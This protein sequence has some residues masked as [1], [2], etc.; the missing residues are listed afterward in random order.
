MTLACMMAFT[1]MPATSFASDITDGEMAISENDASES[2]TLEPAYESDVLPDP[3]P[4]NVTPALNDGMDEN[5]GDIIPD[6]D[7]VSPDADPGQETTGMDLSSD[8]LIEE[9]AKPGKILSYTSD[10][11]FSD[12]PDHTLFSLEVE[13]NSVFEQGQSLLVKEHYGKDLAQDTEELRSLLDDTTVEAKLSFTVLLKNADGTDAPV[14]EELTVRVYAEEKD[15]NKDCNL[16]FYGADKEWKELSFKVFDRT[17]ETN[18]YVEFKTNELGKV[19]FFENTEQIPPS[20]DTDLSDPNEKPLTPENG[21]I[22]SDLTDNVTTQEP[23][24][25]TTAET[26]AEEETTA[27]TQ[28]EEETT[29]ETQAEE[30][31]TAETQAEEAADEIETEGEYLS[32]EI[33][34][35]GDDLIVRVTITEEN[36]IP[37]GAELCV[38]KIDET[39][40]VYQKYFEDLLAFYGVPEE[41]LTIFPYDVHFEFNGNEIEPATGD[42]AVSFEMKESVD[43]AD[44]ETAS[45]LHICDNGEIEEVVENAGNDGEITDFDFTVEAFSGIVIAKLGSGTNLLGAENMTTITF[46][47]TGGVLPI[48]TRQAELNVTTAEDLP[49][50]TKDGHVFLGWFSQR[51]GGYQLEEGDV[52]DRTLY[53]AQWE[54]ITY[55]LILHPNGTDAEPLE[56]TLRYRDVLDLNETMFELDGYILGSWNTNRFGTGESYPANTDV[57]RL[58]ET[59]GDT[60]TLYAIWSDTPYSITFDEQGGSEVPDIQVADGQTAGNK[61]INSQKEGYT[62]LGWYTRPERGIQIKNDTVIHSDYYL[63]ARFEKN[64]VVTFDP[65]D[66]NAVI[67]E[68]DRQRELSYGGTIGELPRVING[69]KDFIGWFTR[70]YG[71]TQISSGAIVYADTTYYAHYGYKPYFDTAEGKIITPDRNQAKQSPS[72]TV[73]SFPVVRR[74]GYDFVGWFLPDGET[75]VQLGDV[76]DLSEDKRIIAHWEPSNKAVITL[77]YDNGT[78]SPKPTSIT[79]YK[80]TALEQL[81][82]PTRTGYKFAGWYDEEG[83]LYKKGTVIT[84]NTALKA[85]WVEKNVTVTF[86]PQG[87][88]NLYYSTMTLPAGDTLNF[89]PGASKDGHILLGWYTQPDGQGEKLTTDTEIDENTTYYAYWVP[90]NEYIDESGL[91]YTYTA[92]WNNNSNSQVNNSDNRLVFTPTS[93]GAVTARLYVNFELEKTVEDLYLPAGALEVR[94]PK[95]VWKSWNGSNI[96]STNI[97]ELFLKAPEIP[98]NDFFNYYEEPDYYV[99]T[100]CVPLNGGAG[101]LKEF[102]YR[103][104]PSSVRG[105]ATDINGDF[106]DG[107]RYFENTVNVSVKIDKELDGVYDTTQRKQLSLEMHTNLK[108]SSSKMA[109]QTRYQ[110]D[111]SWGTKPADAE[112]Y[113]Y[114]IWYVKNWASSSS[115]QGGTYTI[116]EA[117]TTHDGT[118]VYDNFPTSATYT[119]N[120]NE[121]TYT[122]V[123]K[124]SRELL[125][126]AVL[127]PVTLH[128]EAII[129]DTWQSG[130]TTERRVNATTRVSV[131]EHPVGEFD[132][133][134]SRNS[135]IITGGQEQIVKNGQE[136]YIPFYTIYDGGSNV[137]PSWD[138]ATKTYTTATRRMMIQ[139]GRPGDLKYSSGASDPRYAWNANV[140]DCVLYDPD[141]ALKNINITVTEYDSE[142][143]SDKWLTPWAHTDRSTFKP[144]NVYV[145]YRGE[146]DFTFYRTVPL[147]TSSSATVNFPDNVVGYRVEHDSNFFKTQIIVSGAWYLEPTGRVYQLIADDVDHDTTSIIKNQ[148][149]C[150]LWWPQREGV[151]E[152]AGLGEEH[153][154]FDVTAWRYYELNISK[155]TLNCD[156]YIAPA[157]VNAANGTQTSRV[158]I[159]GWNY[160]NSGTVYKTD[161]GVLYDLLPRGVSV[162]KDTVTGYAITSARQWYGSNYSSYGTGQR[163]DKNY[164]NVTFVDNWEGSGRTMMI[165][166]FVVPK[167]IYACGVDFYYDMT[168]SMSNIE[169]YGTARENDLAYAN[170]SEITREIS[171]IR[172]SRDIITEREY[173]DSIAD[174]HTWVAYSRDYT[175]FKTVISE[176]WGFDKSVKTETTVNYVFDGATPLNEDYT[177]KLRMSQSENSEISNLVIYD[178][179]EA[180]TD[181]ITSEWLGSFVSADA[182][183]FT[184]IKNKGE[185]V[186]ATCAPVLY[187]STKPRDEFPDF[188]QNISVEGTAYDLTNTTIWSTQLPDNLGDVTAVAFDMRTDTDGNPMI[189]AGKQSLSVYIRMHSPSNTDLVELTNGNS[190]VMTSYRESSGDTTYEH[191]EA[192]VRIIDSIPELHKT[193]VPES[194]TMEEPAIVS[195]QEPL[196]YTLS[197]ENTG[198]DFILKDVVVEDEIPEGL[199]LKSI[200]VHFG[201]PATKINIEDSPRVSMETDGRHKTFTIS[202]LNKKETCYIVI[203]TLAT[204][205]ERLFVNSS[206]ITSVN[207]IDR[208]I[209]SETTYHTEENSLEVEIRKEK[210]S[211]GLLSGASLQILDSE[212]NIVES[213]VSTSQPH[214][215]RLFPG[216]YTLH[217]ESA[218][219]HFQTAEDITFEVTQD[220]Y[221]KVNGTIA[222]SVKMT[223]VETTDVEGEKYWFGDK[224]SA[225]RPSS[226][227]VNLLRDGEI[228]DTKEVTAADE[229]KYSWTELPKYKEPG[230]EYIYKVV[231]AEVPEGYTFFEGTGEVDHTSTGID[232]VFSSS[233]ETES[234]SYDWIYFYYQKDGIWYR[235]NA[236]GGTSIKNTHVRIP[237]EMAYIEFRSDGS[238]TKYG[239]SF[240]SITSYTGTNFASAT[241]VSGLPS[242]YTNYGTYIGSSYPSYVYY[243]NNQRRRWLYKL[244]NN[245]SWEGHAVIKPVAEGEIPY[246]MTNAKPTPVRIAKIGESNEYLPGAELL[247]TGTEYLSGREVNMSITSAATYSTIDLFPGEYTLHEVLPPPG[248]Y[249][250]QDV[251]FRVSLEGEITFTGTKISNTDVCIKD[252]R[253]KLYVYKYNRS[254]NYLAG[255]TFQIWREADVLDP[256]SLSFAPEAEPVAEWTTQ[257][258][259]QYYQQLLNSGENYWL[260]E[261]EV[262]EGFEK[263]SPYF[264]QVAETATSSTSISVSLYNEW[265]PVDIS[266]S[267]KDEDGNFVEGATLRLTGTAMTN[268]NPTVNATTSVTEEWVTTTEAKHLSLKPGNYVLTEIKRPDSNEYLLN[269]KSISIYVSNDRQVYFYRTDADGVSRRTDSAD[270]VM[271]DEFNKTSLP[272]K[273]V[274]NDA[275]YEENRP[276]SVT[277]ELYQNGTKYE[278]K[279]L[280]SEDASDGYTWEGEFTDLPILDPDDNEYEYEIN[281][282]AD[283]E[284]YRTTYNSSETSGMLITFSEDSDLGDG[285]M[286]LLV[287]KGNS[288]YRSIMLDASD[289]DSE[290]TTTISGDRIGG[291]TI[292]VPTR[293]TDGRIA[294]LL[295]EATKSRNFTITQAMPTSAVY[296]GRDGVRDSSFNET[297]ITSVWNASGYPTLSETGANQEECILFTASGSSE[298]FV[299]A[300]IITNT[301]L[302]T[303]VELKKMWEDGGD[304]ENRPDTITLDLYNEKDLE[305]PVDTIVLTT[306]DSDGRDTWK[307]TI[308][309]LP[310]Y[311]PDGTEA[312]YLYRERSVEGYRTFYSKTDI[313]GARI[314]LSA[315]STTDGGTLNFIVPNSTRAANNYL[316]VN[317][318]RDFTSV[319]GLEVFVPFYTDCHDVF[320]SLTGAGEN[321][322]ITIEN[323]TPISAQDNELGVVYGT[324]GD[325]SETGYFS[326]ENVNVLTENGVIRYRY[327]GESAVSSVGS[328][329]V[330]ESTKTSIMARKTWQDEGKEA[331]RPASVTVE[332][333]NENDPDTVIREAELTGDGNIWELEIQDL[334]RYNQDGTPAHYIVREK[335]APQNYMTFYENAASTGYLVTFAQDQSFE[336]TVTFY[337]LETAGKTASIVSFNGK[338]NLTASDIAGAQIYIEKRAFDGFGFEMSNRSASNALRVESIK[339]VT[340]SSA[341]GVNSYSSPFTRLINPVAVTDITGQSFSTDE[342]GAVQFGIYEYYS[343]VTQAYYGSEIVNRYN[344]TE[345]TAVKK[346]EG[347]SEENRPDTITFNLYTETDPETVIDSKTITKTETQAVFEDLPKYNDDGSIIRYIVKEEEAEGYNTYYAKEE[348]ETAVGFLVEFEKQ[349]YLNSIFIQNGEKAGSIPR[350]KLE[351]VGEKD[352]ASSYSGNMDQNGR[353]LFIPF[354]KDEN[355]NPVRAFMVYGSGLKIKTIEPAY[356]ENLLANAY[357]AEYT[358]TSTVS[359]YN[360]AIFTG[361]DFPDYASVISETGDLN[362][363]SSQNLYMTYIGPG[364]E[365]PVTGNA[366]ITNRRNVKD[367]PFRKIF[368]DAGFESSRPE[369]I[370]VYL[371]DASGNTVSEKEVAVTGSEVTGVFEDIPYLDDAGQEILYHVEEEVPAGYRAFYTMSD[372]KGFLVTFSDDT[373]LKSNSMYLLANPSSSVGDSYYNGS[374]SITDDTYIP[375]SSITRTGTSLAGKTVYIPITKNYLTDGEDPYFALYH[376]LYT[377]PSKTGRSH[378]AI[379]N[380]CLTN[381]YAPHMFTADSTMTYP[382]RYFMKYTGSNY[383]GSEKSMGNYS[384]GSAADMSMYTWSPSVNPFDGCDVIYNRIDKTEVEVTKDWE[385]Y[386]ETT[387]SSVTVDLYDSNNMETP[388]QTKEVS[389]SGKT[390][391]TVF[392]DLVKYDDAGNEIV[393]TAKERDVEGYMAWYGNSSHL[394]GTGGLYVTFSDDTD[395]GASGY[396]V[397]YTD[398]TPAHSSGNNYYYYTDDIKGKTVFVPTQSQNYTI[399][400]M[401]SSLCVYFSPSGVYNDCKLKITDISWGYEDTATWPIYSSGWSI[402]SSPAAIYGMHEGFDSDENNQM[403]SSGYLVFRLDSDANMALSRTCVPGS[404]YIYNKVDKTSIPYSKTWDDEGYEE[405]RPDSVTFRVY[406]VN[407]PEKEIAS[408]TLDAQDDVQGV[409]EDLPKYEEDGT[410]AVYIVKEDP[411]EGYTQTWSLHPDAKVPTGFKVTFSDDTYMTTGNIYVITNTGY[412]K[413]INGA[414]S[415]SGNKL[416][417]QTVYLKTHL[418]NNSYGFF[419]KTYD[420]YMNSTYTRGLAQEG[421]QNFQVINVEP[422]YKDDTSGYNYPFYTSDSIGRN[423][424]YTN[425]YHNLN[426]TYAVTS[427]NSGLGYVLENVPEAMAGLTAITNHTTRTKVE[428]TKSW[429]NEDESS[430]RPGSITVDLY[431]EGSDE[432][433]DTKTLSGN[434]TE[435]VFDDLPKYDE[436]GAEIKYYVKE[437]PVAG[438]ITRYAA[439]DDIV[440]GFYVTFSDDF[441]LPGGNNSYITLGYKYSSGSY[442]YYTEQIVD[443]HGK[444]YQP[445]AEML[446]GKTVFIPFDSSFDNDVISAHGTLYGYTHAPGAPHELGVYEYISTGLSSDIKGGITKITLG[447]EPN[448]NRFVLGGS[449]SSTYGSTFSIESTMTPARGS[450]YPD[451]GMYNSLSSSSGSSSSTYSYMKYIWED[452]EYGSATPSF[453]ATNIVNVYEPYKVTKRWED[454]GHEEDRPDTVTLS[455]YDPENPEE[456]VLTKQFS[457]SG[458]GYEQEYVIDELPV[459]RADGSYIKYLVKEDAVDGYVSKYSM[460]DITGFWLDFD[461][462]KSQPYTGSTSNYM[463]FAG[464]IVQAPTTAYNQDYME[465][466]TSKY[467]YSWKYTSENSGSTYV[468]ARDLAR[469]IFVQKSGGNMDGF[470]LYSNNTYSSENW[471]YEVTGITPVRRAIT[472]E[473]SLSTTSLTSTNYS[474]FTSMQ[475]TILKGDEY[476]KS[477]NY[478]YQLWKWAPVLDYTKVPDCNLIVN[479]INKTDIPVQKTWDDEGNEDKRP[480]SIT[481][482]VYNVRDLSHA[483]K[484]ETVTVNDTGSY[485]IEDL[486]KYN[487]DGTKAQYKIVETGAGYYEP[488]YEMYGMGEAPDGF[489]VKFT[490]D[491]VVTS[492]TVSLFP[493]RNSFYAFGR[494][495][496]KYAGQEFGGSSYLIWS[497]YLNSQTGT[498]LN[499]RYVYIPNTSDNRED[500][501]FML[502]VSNSS[503]TQNRISIE[504]VEPV[505]GSLDDYGYLGEF[506]KDH[507]CING[508]ETQPYINKS[509]TWTYNGAI[510]INGRIG[511]GENLLEQNNYYYIYR[512]NADEDNYNYQNDPAKLIRPRAYRVRNTYDPKK[513]KVE[514]EWDDEDYVSDRPKEVNFTLK[515]GGTVIDHITLTEEDAVDEWHWE[516]EIEDLPKYNADGSEIEYKIEEDVPEGYHVSYGLRKVKALLVT[517][518]DDTAV[519]NGGWTLYSARDGMVGSYNFNLQKAGNTGANKWFHVPVGGN[520][521]YVPVEDNPDSD[522]IDFFIN[523]GHMYGEHVAISDIKPVY[524]DD[525]NFSYISRT[526]YSGDVT[527]TPTRG[528][529]LDWYYGQGPLQ[530]FNKY[531]TTDGTS[532]DPAVYGKYIRVHKPSE[533]VEGCSF[534]NSKVKVPFEKIWDDGGV[535]ELRP[536]KITVSL[537][538]TKDMTQAVTT[539]TFDVV[540]GEVQNAW[541]DNMPRYNDDGT[542]IEWAVREAEVENYRTRYITGE[543]PRGFFVTFSDDTILYGSDTINIH[544]GLNNNYTLGQAIGA[545]PYYANPNISGYMAKGNTFYVQIP[546][547]ANSDR[548]FNELQIVS[549]FTDPRSKYKVVSIIPDFDSDLVSSF[550]T[551]QNMELNNAERPLRTVYGT[552][553]PESTTKETV[554]WIWKNSLQIVNE[555]EKVRL[556]ANKYWD[557]KGFEDLRPDSIVMDVKNGEKTVD[558][559]TL[560]KAG[561]WTGYSKYLPKY[562]EEEEEITYTISERKPDGYTK[563]NENCDITGFRIV[564]SE[565][566]HVSG[567]VMYTANSEHADT[568]VLRDL[569]KDITDSSLKMTSELS[570]AVVYLPI[571]KSPI[572]TRANVKPCMGFVMQVLNKNDTFQIESIEPVSGIPDDATIIFKDARTTS[573]TYPKDLCDR[574]FF[575][576]DLPRKTQEEQWQWFYYEMTDDNL[577]PAHA[578]NAIKKWPVSIRKVNDIDEY[579]AGARL[580]IKSKDTGAVVMTVESNSTGALNAELPSGTYLIHEAY[581]PKGYA[582]PKK[583]IEFTIQED[584]TVI[585]E[586]KPVEDVIVLNKELVHISGTKTWT[587]DAPSDRPESITVNLYANGE[588]SDSV[589]TTAQDEW[590]YD[591][592][593]LE[594][595]DE[596]GSEIIYTVDEE[597]VR[598]YGRQVTD[599]STA[600]TERNNVGVLITLTDLSYIGDG[601]LD[602]YYTKDQKW[603]KIPVASPIAGKTIYVP[604][605]SFFAHLVTTGDVYGFAAQET[606]YVSGQR[607]SGELIAAAPEYTVSQDA[608][609]S[610][611]QV[612][613][614]AGDRYLEF[615]LGNAS[616]GTALTE[617]I[618][619]NDIDVT[620]ENSIENIKLPDPFEVSFK[621][622]DT[623]GSMLAGA[624][625]TLT[626]RESGAHYDI[627]PITFTSSAEKVSVKMLR[628]GTYHLNETKAPAGCIREL[629]AVDFTVEDDGS[630]TIANE[631]VDVVTVTDSE[632]IFRVTKIDK[633]TEVPVSGAVFQILTKDGDIIQEWTT[634]E[635]TKTFRGLLDV[636]TEYMLHEKTVPPSYKAIPDLTFSLNPDGSVQTSEGTSDY[637][638][639][640]SGVLTVLEEKLEVKFRKINEN[641]DPVSGAEFT[642]TG[643]G[644]PAFTQTW[645][646]DG[647]DH[648]ITGIKAGQ[649]TLSETSPTGYSPISPVTITISNTGAVTVTDGS[650]E[651]K[652]T[653]DEDDT[654]VVLITNSYTRHNLTVSKTVEGNF[655]NRT[656]EFTF[657]LKL[658]E[659]QGG[660][661]IP[662]SIRA[663]KILEDQTTET[664]TYTTENGTIEFTLRDG[665]SIRFESIPYG[666]DYKVEE[667]TLSSKGYEVTP[668]NE[669]GTI[670]Q[671]TQVS[672]TNKKDSIVPTLVDPGTPYLY[673]LFALILLSAILF[674]RRKRARL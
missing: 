194:G 572:S 308:K 257:S 125:N 601:T 90:K 116:T 498:L 658:K 331:E 487:T 561:G 613:P 416:A 294:I 566:T 353:K 145:R 549:N 620:L 32:G 223:D 625:F 590:K 510:E 516:K 571:N 332:V 250:N 162:D 113:F 124:H 519:W 324:F 134:N 360:C 408:A 568:N 150:K 586:E 432:I 505:Y 593:D 243:A 434:D 627:I 436:T 265:E 365:T 147:T 233:S 500:C 47:P 247:L 515:A 376:S 311:N 28:A 367:F 607:P 674:F 336:G 378:Y 256:D 399:S 25:E 86:N 91:K 441:E 225:S 104:T 208:H 177:Y 232:F 655:G 31:T 297:K 266:V 181:T 653:I 394:D 349:G 153:S 330:N 24:E 543:N 478:N 350:P 224:N 633:G 94:I 489:I 458:N 493:I 649:Y 631:E 39:S 309:N 494:T 523:G 669:E 657:R 368:D 619:F 638:A 420:S 603:Y 639:V 606:E 587:G 307:R 270:I 99:I 195:R 433:I 351:T 430:K 647:S 140:K 45:V 235:T 588:P 419:I 369:T 452:D 220:K 594:R 329:V 284:N 178:V 520:T 21:A 386:D 37:A 361:S 539:K 346:W 339:A 527:T 506:L 63:Y 230:K 415:L 393:Y 504:S 651:G 278:E 68:K 384:Y 212:N 276:A 72:Y 413:Y 443:A 555:A 418:V 53:F 541:F 6:E 578:T 41:C 475:K 673:I 215:T 558:S 602:L 288:W 184:R 574:R 354:S 59:N 128:N 453:G 300:D 154:F 171:T 628:P 282:I 596:D 42:V 11:M 624:Q 267:K 5:E 26:Q 131:I 547:Q 318:V 534:V 450:H 567:A 357:T 334:E 663:T 333:V 672:F 205:E 623:Q 244:D 89:L 180:G 304:V 73:T 248:H 486:P 666:I 242:G 531:Y 57:S 551:T 327:M 231:E 656:K 175:E 198:E 170:T 187:Y 126:D 659:K 191:S 524:Y 488:S 166:D 158:R 312:R 58:T 106:V 52:Y 667:D 335:S 172:T 648:T 136:V 22:I 238:V 93:D 286:S 548:A 107:Y 310:Q 580:E 152:E 35:E 246:N 272:F 199:E 641:G 240:S 15:L 536:E 114:V 55:T 264:I 85:R 138:D 291:K 518:D 497:D 553:Y 315:D 283:I 157:T 514:K 221:L 17:D 377:N 362:Y 423:V 182:S 358:G 629:Q 249:K 245:S 387:P 40:D 10:A 461:F 439:N 635:T 643:T 425:D 69:A 502:Y 605:L 640:R 268:V 455:F 285:F 654:C 222:P 216:T 371:K 445:R 407:D 642:L 4:D 521:Y 634:D 650:H 391:T 122:V 135:T 204:A 509:L 76:V 538:N 100:N 591:F 542:L 289:Q 292:Y 209:V 253:T 476:P 29:A 454:E 412:D 622:T 174:D 589:T 385:V 79:V 130:Y 544:A 456:A 355:G 193:S 19:F 218:P 142:Q 473:G 437:R 81:P 546:K 381:E 139:D 65:N 579:V 27:E 190:A 464:N 409:F 141:Y 46:N 226:I 34:H 163:L 414:Y 447:Y 169:Y 405:H 485:T 146:S 389:I 313:A 480:S 3:A 525:P 372:P 50:P 508:D 483:V 303:T 296:T 477:S 74:D 550:T 219:E 503:G 460:K 67:A 348:E 173:Y 84:Q 13:K 179:L 328:F 501:G 111:S 375:F 484:T 261:T 92:Y 49:V 338:R 559:I 577:I 129:K 533:W 70:P 471:K 259:S 449:N 287:K 12:D 97:D 203:N 20:E 380:I 422:T 44:D 103:V 290:S 511:T 340:L 314:K 155:D 252:Y 61:M 255:C 646:S 96:G 43:V 526:T 402:P 481:F 582:A 159:S 637:L 112:D 530:V 305:T 101:F 569:S 401:P 271:Y 388:V 564:F 370:T 496:D 600:K 390:T 151:P 615:H 14:T 66:E 295:S 632:T 64:P 499:N 62:F 442:D 117:N 109:Y 165:I 479:E 323:V 554:R 78:A 392:T 105:G 366:V 251:Q 474:N 341:S 395:L 38:E 269:P 298:S 123:T 51:E 451:L 167:G 560:T 274:W 397:M 540:D 595:Y 482:T 48:K 529:I 227:T 110:W 228:I 95:Y 183:D 168:D 396:V 321:A 36:R 592:G 665:V 406:N 118:I 143:V 609:L 210:D 262:P 30:E 626:G 275:N 239:F 317:G 160:N 293:G 148:A 522:T 611:S 411:V 410:E 33:V 644:T 424:P 363:S 617:D 77:D 8:L 621:K 144:V 364:K 608:L 467:A 16:A 570:G 316:Y 185:E 343:G 176:T 438:Y 610:F 562:D 671:D 576:S 156:K 87:G 83:N 197:I 599:G 575:N 137:I 80:N 661:K 359:L 75:Q 528:D 236:Y 306:E 186:T 342:F 404:N 23:E 188:D 9:D 469:P 133:K 552:D 440:N 280:T 279:T 535:E 466:T 277:F 670:T 630:V 301:S 435:G 383:P 492:G 583:D 444:Y 254:S 597:I 127:N 468:Y 645:T 495:I 234:T 427:Y 517:F 98:E 60:V 660:A 662:E 556:K 512:F 325:T 88:S 200:Q 102:E 337:G 214:K 604:T 207:G 373:D 213:W 352:Y 491:T 108:P 616:N 513:L 668:D 189:F 7:P 398:K 229:W 263:L 431:A 344:K 196:V 532:V 446:R 121:A 54:E 636:E 322:S 164:Y 237:S 115:T 417:G 573:T 211:R 379:T 490:N 56:Y 260:I 426:E 557:D 302:L 120:G 585:M 581:T 584:G 149:N 18:P 320:L 299:G 71:G 457:V 448:K 463:T 217:E 192:S 612:Q 403:Y 429:Q 326:G 119:L 374:S 356:D 421:K 598:G 82:S 241:T 347:D 201:D 462:E 202:R 618:V 1:T 507:Y 472:Y 206:E 545:Q 652:V 470:L 161:T 563:K 382:R 465:Y 614:S 565:D 537:Y 281:E 132:K 400:S 345:I 319:S 273:K 664:T 428:F 258:G 459:Q 2:Q